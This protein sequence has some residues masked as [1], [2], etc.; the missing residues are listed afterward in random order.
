MEYYLSQQVTRIGRG[1]DNDVVISGDKQVSRYHAEIRRE[2][3]TLVLYDLNSRNGTRVNG[4]RVTKHRLRDGDQIQV[5]S[6]RMNFANGVLIVSDSAVGVRPGPQGVAPAYRERSG[7]TWIAV[8][9][10][11]VVVVA[12][13]LSMA[14][15][16]RPSTLD[17]VE[18]AGRQWV[19]QRVNAIALE[20]VADPAARRI[21]LEDEPLFNLVSERVASMEN[22]SFTTPEKVAEGIYR[23]VATANLGV[24]LTEGNFT[25]V[26]RYSLTVNMNT[27]VVTAEGPQVQVK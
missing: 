1:L 14:L 4:A 18:S 10:A 8:A 17:R 25:V 2:G 22:W 20:I 24:P 11:A 21:P 23:L 6:T 5:G 7:L 19:A 16:G 12:I 15:A 3:G 9:G 13:I 27:S 26:A